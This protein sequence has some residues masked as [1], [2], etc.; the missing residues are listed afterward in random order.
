MLFLFLFGNI[1]LAIGDVIL[2]YEFG[3]NTFAG[4]LLPIDFEYK[5][6]D[7]CGEFMPELGSGYKLYPTVFGS[8]LVVL[9]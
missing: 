4:L 9:E 2:R 3:L 5:G 6:K 8:L 7:Y 1:N